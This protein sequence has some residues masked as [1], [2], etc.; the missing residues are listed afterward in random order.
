MQLE[1]VVAKRKNSVYEAGARSANWQ[2]LKLE[3]HQEFVI[4]GYRPYAADS[5][6]A[7]LVGY[8]DNQK[9]RFAGKVR[10]GLVSHT[11]RE[12]AQKLRGLR[13]NHCPFVD[14]PTEGSSR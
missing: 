1:G 10:G 12:L 13:L 4:G 11:R 2:K 3:R 8:F 9:L 5:V 6:D 14:L 7:L